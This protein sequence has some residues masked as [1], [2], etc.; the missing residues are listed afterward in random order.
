M[1]AGGNGR[2]S[3]RVPSDKGAEVANISC[4]GDRVAIKEV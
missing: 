3:G 4:G 1:E 2:A